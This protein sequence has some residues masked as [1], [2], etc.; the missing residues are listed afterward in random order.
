M[1][2][3][4]NEIFDGEYHS[5][6]MRSNNFKCRAAFVGYARCQGLTIDEISKLIIGDEQLVIYRENAHINYYNSDP[7]YRLKFDKLKIF[8]NVK[9]LKNPTYT[10]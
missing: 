5:Y 3:L 9:G 2:E 10:P 1:I 8:P 7:D 4:I 6:K